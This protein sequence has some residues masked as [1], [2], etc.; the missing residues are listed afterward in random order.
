MK[1]PVILF[2][3]PV[4]VSI[5]LRLPDVSASRPTSMNDL[6]PASSAPFFLS[7]PAKP[8]SSATERTP[9][10]LESSMSSGTPQFCDVASTTFM[11]LFPA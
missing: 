3:L 2:V 4:L 6:I 7:F 5:L 9:V 1:F 11:T 8:L 10:Y